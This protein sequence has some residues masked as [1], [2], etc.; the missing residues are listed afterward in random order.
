[1]WRV[2]PPPAAERAR[3]ALLVQSRTFELFARLHP[4]SRFSQEAREP[5]RRTSK[6]AGVPTE[7][8]EVQA[9]RTRSCAQRDESEAERQYAK[10]ERTA[11]RSTWA[12]QARHRMVIAHSA[13]SGLAS[14][15]R[16]GDLNP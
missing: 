8:P 6:S 13:A 11:G 3:R 4:S 16:I 1:M 14:A 12:G 7:G 2:T 5:G 9:E 10:E 15:R